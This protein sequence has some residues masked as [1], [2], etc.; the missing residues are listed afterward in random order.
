MQG[1]SVIAVEDDKFCQETLKLFLTALKVDF[2]LASNGEEAVKAF[3]S[4]PASLVL[5]DL[6]M[7]VMDGFKAAKAIRDFEASAGKG[8]SKII[9]LSGGF[10]GIWVYNQFFI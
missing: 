10:L 1:K 8:K 6:N 9:G 5:M 2:T 4:K 7:P 3:K